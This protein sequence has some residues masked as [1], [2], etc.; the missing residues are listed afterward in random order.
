MHSIQVHC[1][2]LG[3]SFQTHIFLQNLVLIQPRTSP[4]KILNA[5][6]ALGTW[7]CSTTRHAP[8]PA[9]LSPANSTGREKGPQIERLAIPNFLLPDLVKL[10][11]YPITSNYIERALL[12]TFFDAQSEKMKRREE[13]ARGKRSA[14][15]S[16]PP[17]QPSADETRY[18][19]M[20]TV[21][22]GQT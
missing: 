14:A 3:E 19:P 22:V 16:L 2:D 4:L 21:R 9:P 8:R 12:R 6:R 11:N 13:K 15:A 1:V 10:L 18:L 20:V 7:P 17:S 5:H